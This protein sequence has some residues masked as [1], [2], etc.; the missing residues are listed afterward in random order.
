[1]S[2]TRLPLSELAWAPSPT[3]SLESKKVIAGHGA[4][5][6]RFAPGFSD[7]NWCERSHVLYVLEGALEFELPDRIER[8]ER[9]DA[10]WVEPGSPHRARNPGQS[11]A[12]VF[13]VSD[14]TRTPA[15]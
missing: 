4:A 15:S 14:V 13:V 2:V 8:M 6:L 7:P 1:M 3:H 11:D 9:G 10:C 5:L 12:V